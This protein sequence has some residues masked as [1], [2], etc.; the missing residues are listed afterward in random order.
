MEL[1]KDKFVLLNTELKMEKNLQFSCWS[2]K[3]LSVKKSNSNIYFD[4]IYIFV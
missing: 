3:P 1:Q 4:M 2:K